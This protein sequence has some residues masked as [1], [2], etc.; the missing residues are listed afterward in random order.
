MPFTRI[1]VSWSRWTKVPADLA[2]SD[3]ERQREQLNAALE[4]AR[5]NALAHFGRSNV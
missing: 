4:R 2:E 5:K 1:A 3:V